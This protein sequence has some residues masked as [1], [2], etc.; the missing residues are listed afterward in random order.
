LDAARRIIA[1]RTSPFDVARVNA[2]GKIDYCVTIVGWAG[3]ADINCKAERLRLLGPPRYAI[4]ALWQ[5]LFQKRRHAQLLLDGRTL[6]D[7][8]LLVVACNTIFA[9][10]G[11]R[12]TPRAKVDDGKIDLVILRNASRWQMF[13]L[14]VK[15]F[16]GSHVDMPCV[17]YHQVRSL[18]IV[19]DDRKPLDLDG[20]IKGAP[21][22]SILVLPGAV[23]VFV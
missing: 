5:I 14:F 20:E 10:S 16:D 18:S 2:G 13:R 23:R 4:A 15:V 22:V 1:G 9:G 17:E 7:D 12:L 3:V 21:P 8:F 11:M 19:S 6:E